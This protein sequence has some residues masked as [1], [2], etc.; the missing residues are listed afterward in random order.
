MFVIRA[1]GK[2]RQNEAVKT[3]VV[4]SLPR[5]WT[6]PKFSAT[7]L[8]PKTLSLW[9]TSLGLSPTKCLTDYARYML[10][11]LLPSK[12]DNSNSTGLL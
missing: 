8:Y 4:A 6:Q 11:D 5:C 10:A 1:C 7:A 3:S 9:S 12:L 2:V